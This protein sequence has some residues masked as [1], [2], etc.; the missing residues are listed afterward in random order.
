[1]SL[2]RGLSS[3][4]RWAVLRILSARSFN[5]TMVNFKGRQ[6]IDEAELWAPHLT[7]A[8]Y[9]AKKGTKVDFEWP[10]QSEVQAQRAHE[11]RVE[12][13]IRLSA[14]LQGLFLLVGIGAAGTAYLKW[15]QIMSWWVTKDDAKVD[16]DTIEKLIKRKTKRSKSE[17]AIVSGAE[18]GPD[19][20]GLYLAGSGGNDVTKNK[21]DYVLPKRI[22]VFDQQYLRDVCLSNGDNGSYNLAI[23]LKGN[24]LRWNEQIREIILPDQNLLKVKLSNGCAYALNKSGEIYVIPVENPS[25]QKKYMEN[26]R[27]WLFPWKTYCKYNWKLDTK[28]CFKARGEKKIVQFDTG[29]QHLVLLSNKGKAYSCATGAGT[30]SESTSRGQFGVPS[31]S[32]FDEFPP[33]NRL[34]EIELLNKALDPNNFVY[35]RNIKQVA[36]GNYHT[37]A[38]DAEGRIFGFGVNRNG[39]LGLPISYDNEQVPFPKV[40]NRFGSYF[41]RDSKVG[42]VDIHCADNTSY[43]T[44]ETADDGE[45]TLYYFS[46]GDGQQGELGN[47]NYTTCQT[48]PTQLKYTGPPIE[49]W[50]CGGHHV[51]CKLSDGEV[52]AWGSNNRGQL[53]NGRH[54]KSGKPQRIPELLKPGVNATTEEIF[55][56]TLNL[57]PGQA[58][59]TGETNSCIYW[60]K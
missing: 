38:R 31:L 44:M 45:K 12:K 52:I 16:D 50:N 27:S 40:I 29:K 4:R 28:K 51:W 55:Q 58:I 47:G 1:M 2:R 24:L 14:M 46:F 18:F 11:A 59:A 6:Q 30:K 56:S 53:G 20:P 13:L 22:S 19:V 26:K 48:E 10:E 3:N 60:T 21:L 37:L 41:K 7:S 9:K 35:Q 54:I 5:G 39:Q 57:Q 42:C 25:L 33:C 23:D 32:Q 36:C 17:I 34:F 8:P 15:P 43:V 49:K